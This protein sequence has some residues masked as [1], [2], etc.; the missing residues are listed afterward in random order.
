MMNDAHWMQQAIALAEQGRYTTRPNPAVGCVIVKANNI[1]GEGWHRYAGEWHAEVHALQAAG[2]QAH[3]ATAYVT[4]EPFSHHGK[5]PPCAQA[6]IE[7]QV[8]RVVIALQD[9]NPKVAG[10]GIALLQQAGIAVD[11]GCEAAAAEALNAGFLFSMRH[12][13]PLVRCKV[14]SSIDGRT[15]MASGESQ[16]IT[17]KAA[18]LHAQ[19]LRAQ[20]G[21]IITGSGTVLADD[22]ALTVRPQEWVQPP[23]HNIPPPIRV[24][25]DSQAKT[26][27][28]ARILH[29]P[30]AVWLTHASHA[31]AQQLSALQAQGVRTI[32]LGQRQVDLTMLLRVLHEAQI[33]EVMIEAGSRLSGAFLAAGLV[34]ELW[35]YQ[36]PMVLGEATQ[37]MFVMPQLTELKNRIELSRLQC[38]ML[39]QDSCHTWR[40]KHKD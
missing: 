30:G 3:G 10:Q 26:P 8:A 40:V 33:H 5:T 36:A 19:T 1:V 34:D 15:A 9:P 21:A 22:P 11:V 25:V 6:L 24:I 16:W 13:R 23:Q 37:G 17:G 38:I 14:A 29:Q 18:R 35:H 2:E 7:A 32:M 20:S 27:L 39:D 12:G 31:D 4:F 28:N